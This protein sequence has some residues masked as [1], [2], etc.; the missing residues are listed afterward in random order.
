MEIVLHFCFYKH[1]ARSGYAPTQSI[2][3]FRFWY[4]EAKNAR[5]IGTVWLLKHRQWCVVMT[6]LA[7]LLSAFSRAWVT[8]HALEFSRAGALLV[9]AGLLSLLFGQR[10]KRATRKRWDDIDDVLSKYNQTENDKFVRN[11]VD[12]AEINAFNVSFFVT[13]TGTLVWA[14]GDQLMACW[15]FS[16]N[17]IKDISGTYCF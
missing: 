8:E 1:L 2:L 17:D 15:I 16:L 4:F 13:I 12:D 10:G 7:I 14:Y 5:N 9:I 6:S 11:E 3:H